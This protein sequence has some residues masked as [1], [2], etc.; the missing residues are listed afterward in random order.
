MKISDQIKERALAI[1][2]ELRKTEGF[3]I[4]LAGYDSDEDW[5]AVVEGNPPQVIALL[6]T[7]CESMAN[8]VSLVQH[9]ALL[10]AIS[11]LVTE[12]LV[13]YHGAVPVTPAPEKETSGE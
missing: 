7:L 5:M 4:I 2:D 6:Q 1:R 11:M 10:V 3:G 13:K 9:R 8:Q 12:Q